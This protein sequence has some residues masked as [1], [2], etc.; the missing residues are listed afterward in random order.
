LETELV[1][2]SEGIDEELALGR[3]DEASVLEKIEVVGSSETVGVGCIVSV[4][5]VVSSDVL[6]DVEVI[7]GSE[8]VGVEPVEVKISEG[9]DVASFELEDIVDGGALKEGVSEETLEEGVTEETIEAE[10][11]DD[12]SV[13]SLKLADAVDKAVLKEDVGEDRDETKMSETVDRVAL[14]LDDVVDRAPL[15]EDV[16]EEVEGEDNRIPE[17]EKDDE[18]TLLHFPNPAWQPVPQYLRRSYQHSHQ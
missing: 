5:N 6:S 4:E 18:T 16:C 13:T 14:E 8:D 7:S 17:D 2:D 10:T 1:G 9:V 11:S 12:V 15:E 3:I